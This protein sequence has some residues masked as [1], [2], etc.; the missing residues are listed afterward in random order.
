MQSEPEVSRRPA[1]LFV[2]LIKIVG[3]GKNAREEILANETALL[4]F[5]TIRRNEA[6]A[7]KKIMGEIGFGIDEKLSEVF[8]QYTS[9]GVHIA[10]KFPGD[11]ANFEAE[12][13]KFTKRADAK[14]KQVMNNIAVQSGV[15]PPWGGGQ[16][17]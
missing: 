12:I 7:K 8:G 17:G 4:G 6:M 2:K 5:V 1:W 15:K 16:K 13:D 9:L 11:V 10:L 3:T 14:V